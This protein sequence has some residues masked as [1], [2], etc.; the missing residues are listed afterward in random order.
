MK[1]IILFILLIFTVNLTFGQDVSMSVKGQQIDGDVYKFY[2]SLK[3]KGFTGVDDISSF[4]NRD[5][6]VT[7]YGQ[8]FD[9]HCSIEIWYTKLSNQVY[10]VSIVYDLA[11]QNINN[12]DTVWTL[13]SFAKSQLTLKYGKPHDVAE[14]MGTATNNYKEVGRGFYKHL[15][16]C[17][18][19]F[20]AKE[21]NIGL[22]VEGK[23][24]DTSYENYSC[25][26]TINYINRA[27]EK[28]NKDE[29]INY[30]QSEI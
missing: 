12:W 28:I 24:W 9:R 26:V 14:V 11:N 4:V 29:M 20:D 25:K 19:V 7:L 16:F 13:Y 3:S 10:K 2:Q 27:N 21:G 5:E 22:L 23:K 6:V 18:C 30:Y 17:Q 8:I 1:R 15:S